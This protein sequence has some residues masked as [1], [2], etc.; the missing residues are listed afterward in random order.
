MPTTRPTSA[1]SSTT[2][3]RQQTTATP[4]PSPSNSPPL[5][6]PME[7]STSAAETPSPSTECSLPYAARGH[8]HLLPA[9]GTYSHRAIASPS[10]TARPMPPSTTPPMAT[11]PAPDRHST[12]GPIQVSTS[13]IL[14]AVAI[15]PGFSQSA[16]GSASYTIG[17]GSSCTAP[18]LSGRERMPAGRMAQL[19]LR[20]SPYSRAATVTGTIARMEVWVDGVKKFST[21]NSRTLS[22]SLSPRRRLSHASSFY[23]VNTAGTKW[24][25]TVTA[26]V[27]RRTAA[28][29]PP[30]TAGVNCM[31]AG[32]RFD[33]RFAGSGS[34]SSNSDRHHRTNGSLGRW[35]EEVQ[36]LQQPLAQHLAQPR[37]RLSPL[38]LLRSEYRRNEVARRR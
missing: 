38:H 19:S 35:R 10:R 9:G 16:V 18:S 1:Q 3:P 4:R 8:A 5:P 21:F 28:C 27:R 17:T 31:Q 11:R 36:H 12:P 14:Q 7:T 29:N 15:A 34:V 25:Q 20:R 30:S 26:T 24:T 32:E 23:A 33:R 2:A 6:S 13:E 22:T 37:L